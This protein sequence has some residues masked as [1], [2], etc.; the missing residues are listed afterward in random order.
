MS[1][2]DDR[3]VGASVIPIRPI[4]TGMSA[5]AGA[6]VVD[7]DG[8]TAIWLRI[9]DGATDPLGDAEAEVACR[10]IE[11][12]TTGGL[13]LVVEIAG[14]SVAPAQGI[15]ALAAWGSIARA[16]SAASGIVATVAIV[17]GPVVTGLALLLGLTDVVVMTE[18]AEV[19]VSSPA[20]V[21][22]TTG[23]IIDAATLGGA[24]AHGGRSGVAQLVVPDADHAVATVAEL[25]SYL[26]A[27]NAD[28]PL[29]TPTLDPPDRRCDRL[30]QLVPADPRRSYDVRAVIAELADDADVLELGSGFGQAMVCA[31]VRLG[32]HSVGVV[33][34]QPAH[35]AG[36]IDIPSSQKAARFV[37][38]CDALG[39]PLLTLVDTPGYL[40][41]RDLEWDGMIRHGGQLA[42]AY[43]AAT[44]PRMCVLMRK[45]YGGAYI[46][47][48]CK[49]MGNDVCVAWPQ[50]EIAVMGAAG[51]VQIL[52][53]RQLDDLP[54][55]DAIVERARLEDDYTE[56]YLNPREALAR[57]YVDDVID[58]ART[59]EVLVRALP[60]LLGKRT[61]P[62]VRKHH[63]GPL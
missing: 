4:A 48:D 13:P 23:R 37:Q 39:L 36:A 44:V 14:A 29:R 53:A 7:V 2:L 22:T 19:F 57:G 52:A 26:P 11:A 9:G 60:T 50:A 38:W 47:M 5:H 45:A 21:A 42:F 32:G 10:A 1:V 35:L 51:A 30:V 12:A 3:L 6:G 55:D 20:A 58:P 46:V 28:A 16:L 8:H 63:N 15:A 33:A 59:R 31:F 40:P 41:G 43:A 17:D 27:N 62:P 54:P 24:S 25:L 34:N 56:R 61:A 18:A 49:T